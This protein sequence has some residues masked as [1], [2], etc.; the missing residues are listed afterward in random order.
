MP[1]CSLKSFISCSTFCNNKE[2][3]LGLIQLSFQVFE[4]WYHIPPVFSRLNYPA[5][6]LLLP[7]HPSVFLVWILKLWYPKLNGILKIVS[8]KHQIKGSQNAYNWICFSATISHF[9]SI[10]SLKSI[11][12]LLHSKDIHSIIHM[13]RQFFPSG[14]LFSSNLLYLNHKMNTW[15]VFSHTPQ[16]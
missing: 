15:Q 3:I 14:R 8:N 4:E 11:L 12:M 5:P 7:C 10:F 13:V 2:Q 6:S 16:N 1:S 9:W